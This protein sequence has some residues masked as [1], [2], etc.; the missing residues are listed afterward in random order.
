MPKR[1]R[2]KEVVAALAP[3]REARRRDTWLPRLKKGD[4]PA[5]A[6]KFAGTPWLAEGEPWPACRVCHRAMDLFLQ[7]N[8]GKLPRALG[9]RFGAGLLQVFYCRHTSSPGDCP[10]EG[11]EAFANCQLAR[12]VHP[13]PRARRK[14][15][16]PKEA[17]G[18]K[19]RMI[20]GWTRKDD[21]PDPSEFEEQGLKIH[22]D[23]KGKLQWARCP[24]LGFVSEKLP[25][26]EEGLAEAVSTAD[27]HDKL[28][29]WP[30]WIHHPGY[31]KCPRCSGRMGFVYQLTG[32]HLPFM[33]GDVGIGYVT[34]CPKHPDVVAFTWQCH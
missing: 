22:Y 10:G 12:V 32:D 24:E 17:R 9:G 30:G 8:L 25:L 33:F 13:P 21:Y 31:P 4:G 11:Y 14:P 18:F 20:V 28:W 1:S 23:F 29:S 15:P 7:L 6:S 5:T 19:P 3:W 16:V 34:Q 2:L 27:G 26:G